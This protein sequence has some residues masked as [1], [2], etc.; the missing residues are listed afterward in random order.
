MVATINLKIRHV[1]FFTPNR[2]TMEG[3]QPETAYDG[4]GLQ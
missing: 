4:G 3:Q 2:N 1:T